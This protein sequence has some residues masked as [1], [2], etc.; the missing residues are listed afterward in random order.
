MKSTLSISIL[1]LLATGSCVINK[2]VVQQNSRVFQSSFESES[3]FSSFY[4]VPQGSYDSDH[5]LSA[6]MAISGSYSHKAWITAPR[7]DNNDGSIYLPHR[8]YPTIQL[9]KTTKGSFVTPCIITFY[10]YLDITLIDRPSGQIDDW[11][12]F[13][14]LSPDN[15]DNWIRTILVNIAPDNLLR[16]VHV[17]DQG[18][19]EYIYQNTVLQY[20]HSEWVR[21]SIYIDLSPS[22][23]YAKVYQN[24]TLVSH[25]VVNGGNGL[26]EQA[27]FGLYS[28]AATSSGTIFNDDLEIREV[29]DET[30]ASL[31]IY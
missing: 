1:L 22:Y 12:S 14:T 6:E 28:S 13:A 29:G 9:Y 24:G 31:Y 4:I 21:I 20:P 17:P 8:A 27:H 19:Q 30:E 3:D 18:K 25:A 7:A 11:F 15:S 23:G 5:E 16:L 10:T 26:L 2:E